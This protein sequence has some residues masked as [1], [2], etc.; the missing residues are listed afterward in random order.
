MTRWTCFL[1]KCLLMCLSLPAQASLFRDPVLQQAYE[2]DRLD[3]L[4]LQA[5]K[6]QGAEALAGQG[7]AQALSNDAAALRRAETAAQEC[8][9]QYP[10]AAACHYAQARV[11]GVQ[12]LQGGWMS[13]LR[14]LRPL[15]SALEQVLALDPQLAEARHALQQLLLLMP[16]GGSVDRARELEREVRDSQPVLAT[17]LR[18]NLA[19]KDKQWSVVERELASLG[20]VESPV[21]QG[22]LMEAWNGYSRQWMKNNQHQ[23][24]QALL[25]RLA[26]QY[27]QQAMP[28]YL[29]GRVAADAGAHAQAI[30]HYER[31]QALEG[32]AALPLALRIG[33]AHQ[34]LGATAAARENLQRALQHRQATPKNLEDAQRRL[35]QLAAAP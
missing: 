17:L 2:Q 25:E 1:L 27:P 14:L 26:R 11:L 3:A 28:A 35:K 16:L 20:S 18:A 22:L 33:I 8:V 21:L 29:L 23:A 31:A 13:G 19:S 34:D 6:G 15:R 9:R 30:A 7:L 32:A 4:L 24:A 10:E 12:A 5:R